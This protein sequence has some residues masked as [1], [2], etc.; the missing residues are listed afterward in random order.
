LVPTLLVYRKLAEGGPGVMAEAVAKAAEVAKHHREAFEAALEAGVKI[1]G[2]TD[3]YSPN[4][5]PYPRIIDE[6]IT[7]EEYGMA[8][9][10]VLKA[11]T[12]NASEALGTSKI[13]GAVKEGLEAD[14]VLLRANPLENL[15][16]LRSVRKVFLD[17]VEIDPT[18]I[19]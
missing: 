10:E 4:F 9:S 16:N 1:A 5:G 18:H 3:V 7:M 2:G 19:V 12:L 8:R 11:I 14:L 13:R 17:G 15:E 6:A